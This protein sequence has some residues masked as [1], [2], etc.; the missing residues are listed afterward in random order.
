MDNTGPSDN[1]SV[2]LG[3]GRTF[4]F[5]INCNNKTDKWHILRQIYN[6]KLCLTRHRLVTESAGWWPSSM[7]MIHLFSHLG[8]GFPGN[9]Y[10]NR[11]VVHC[12][13]VLTNRFARE[14]TM[15]LTVIEK[16]SWSM[17]NASVLWLMSARY[18]QLPWVEVDCVRYAVQH[19]L[20]WGQNWLP[21]PAIPPLLIPPFLLLG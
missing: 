9:K 14:C 6:W 10:K 7:V 19:I 4:N 16:L 2:F 3:D 21:T 17:L 12:Y 8:V 20:Y 11:G 5:N 15:M 13:P 1:D 18:L